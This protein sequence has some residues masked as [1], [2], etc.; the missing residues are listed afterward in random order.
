MISRY[1]R[2][3]ISN[4]FPNNIYDS[5]VETDFHEVKENLKEK[6]GRAILKHHPKKSL[7]QLSG[8]FDSSIVASYFYLRNI[9]TFCTGEETAKDRVISEKI[10]DEFKTNHTWISHKELLNRINFKEAMI[11]MA[12]INRYPRCFK[13][14]FGL[15]AFL[16]Y[17]RDNDY[18]NIMSGKG[19]EFQ[20]LGYHT[21]YNKIVEH[22]IGSGEYSIGMAKKYLGYKEFNSPMDSNLLDIKNIINSHY[23]R[24]KYNLDFV[25][26]WSGGF[27]KEEVERLTGESQEDMEFNTADEIIDFIFEW[28][29]REYVEKRTEDY[30][31][32]FG[33]NCINPYMNEELVDYIKRIPMEM[34]KS[35]NYHKYVFYQAI[36]NRV[37][38]YIIER[39]KEGLNTSLIYFMDHSKEISEL[40]DEY[41]KDTQRKIWNYIDRKQLVIDNLDLI[42]MMSLLNLSIWMEHNDTS[43]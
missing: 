35:M 15:Y 32:Y 22:A 33:V 29:G 40:I 30:G 11:D 9:D 42:R 23:H 26:W 43:I 39:E 34:K 7:F 1:L 25:N 13:N 5:N 14:D 4:E 20:M 3:G 16:K 27:S 24:T 18:E 37:P 36:G 2:Y 21:I 38:S 28:F 17:A 19:I 41:L 31:N 8:G 6:V 10:S 12:E